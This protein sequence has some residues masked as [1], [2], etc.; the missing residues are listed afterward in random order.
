LANSHQ[1]KII[2]NFLTI[3]F[4]FGLQPYLYVTIAGMKRKTLKQHKEVTLVCEKGISEVEAINN[5]S[6]P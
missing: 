6:I 3:I 1:H 2:D 5:P 4:K